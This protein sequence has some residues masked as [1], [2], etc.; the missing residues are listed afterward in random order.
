MGRI[1]HHIHPFRYPSAPH[2]RRHGPAGYKNYRDYRPWLEDEFI[3]RCV[4]CL[5]RQRWALTD[6]WSVEHLIPQ[7]EAPGLECDY[8]NLVLTCQWCN[9]RK[10]ADRVPDPVA[11]A[12]GN[13]L[14]VED[15]SAQVKALND[16]G[17]ILL[18]VLKLNHDNVVSMRRDTMRTLRV[19]A[20]CSLDDWKRLMGFPDILPNL[21]RKDPPGG[22][23]RPDGLKDCWYER[24]QR[25]ALPEVYE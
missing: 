10:L 20:Q 14:Q 22:N 16:D 11:V 18:R 12:Y 2:I 4:Y 25:N 24:K 6:I 13:C 23:N 3:F 21:G 15:D 17:E 1:T 19:M 5:K 7:S 9:N 8:D